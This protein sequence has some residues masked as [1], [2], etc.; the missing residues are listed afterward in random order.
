[1]SVYDC[2]YCNDTGELPARD[3]V[4]YAGYC[5]CS[6]GVDQR[7]LDADPLPQPDYHAISDR[8]KD[9]HR[10]KML[11]SGLTECPCG[12][13]IEGKCADKFD[14]CKKWRWL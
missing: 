11:A 8:L 10:D 9:E 12:R 2:P 13:W 7:K 1:M 4:K 6:S 3:D 14:E 5:T